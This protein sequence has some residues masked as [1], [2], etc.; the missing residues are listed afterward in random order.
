MARTPGKRRHTFAKW[1][2][3]VVVGA[4]VFLMFL[5]RKAQSI[6]EFRY[7]AGAQCFL[8]ALHV[9][10][11]EYKRQHGH[12]PNGS[13]LPPS[14]V[15]SS[16]NGRGGH[17]TREEIEMFWKACRLTEGEGRG[18]VLAY[19]P[20]KQSM[21]GGRAGWNILKDNGKVQGTSRD[22]TQGN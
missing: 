16:K 14:G 18:G 9:E 20:A 7:D 8:R 1:M 11:A 10:M 2:A 17:M 22:P 21:A 4:I 6:S 3:I 12:W 15:A 5:A 13:S 19:I